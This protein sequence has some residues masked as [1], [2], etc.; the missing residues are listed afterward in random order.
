MRACVCVRYR[1]AAE[2]VRRVSTF[3]FFLVE[4][5]AAGCTYAL[6]DT[7]MIIM[8]TKTMMMVSWRG[9]GEGI[10]SELYELE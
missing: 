6:K 3:F 8:T 2:T 4:T 5:L 7:A 9:G 10:T 1:T